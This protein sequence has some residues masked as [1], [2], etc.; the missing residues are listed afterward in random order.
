MHE[1][2][3]VESML[4]IIE[5]EARAR[6]FARVLA[7]RVAVG[8]LGSVEP[9]ALQFCFDAVCRGSLADGASL[10]IE[11]VPGRAW[12]MDCSRQVALHDRLADCPECG[13]FALQIE[14]GDE[15]RLLDLEVQ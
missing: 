11:R 14:R 1:L 15:L 3:L 7:V 10:L 8:E 2:S 13:G 4:G 9:Q 12:C 5:Q 6:G